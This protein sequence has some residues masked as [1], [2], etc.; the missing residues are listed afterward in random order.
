MSPEKSKTV[1]KASSQEIS[2]SEKITRIQIKCDVGFGNFL[3]IR[4]Q[5]G[6][7]SWEKG[8][9]LKNISTDDWL[10]ETNKSFTE[11]EFKV[12]INDS[13]YENG[14]NHMIEHGNQIQYRP[15]FQ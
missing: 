9:Q 6:E 13:L 11:I 7:L 5:G 14:P 1:A 4:G 15:K 10:F 8:L 3:T 2:K 12:L